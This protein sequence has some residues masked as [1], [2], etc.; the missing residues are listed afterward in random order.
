MI[1]EVYR[2]K[3]IIQEMRLYNIR[4]KNITRDKKYYKTSCCLPFGGFPGL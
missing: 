1:D 4:D 3:I 2:L